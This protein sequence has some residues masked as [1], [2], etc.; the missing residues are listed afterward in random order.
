[1]AEYKYEYPEVD[2]KEI[3]FSP[4][5]EIHKKLRNA[6]DDKIRAGRQAGRDGRARATELDRTLNSFVPISDRENFLKMK[7]IDRP[8]EPLNIVIPVSKS[9]LDTWIT[10]MA[11]AFLGNPAGL[12]QLQGRGGP[13]GIV[14]AALHERFLNTQSIWFDHDLRHV[15]CWRDAFAYGLGCIAPTWGKHKRREPVIE[16]VSETLWYMIRN[17]VPGVK[18]GDVIRYLEERVVHEGNELVNVD[19]YSLI[20]D[21]NV[22]VSNYRRFEYAG[23]IE[24]TNVLDLLGKEPDPEEHLFNVK[25]LRDH[26]KSGYGRSRHWEARGQRDDDSSNLWGVSV[27]ENVTTDVIHLYWRLIPKDWGL[28]DSEEPEVHCFLLG[29]DEVIIGW[30][31]IDYDHGMLPMLFIAPNSTGYDTFPVSGLANT[32]GGQAF[33]DWKTRSMVA[34][35]AKVLNDMILIDTSMF[36]EDD[37]M[38]PEPGKLI[39]AKRSLYGMGGMDQFVKQLTTHDSS[40]G[41]MND[42]AAM[43]QIIFQGLGTVDMVQGDLSRAPD[44]PTAQGLM[45]ARNSALSRL[46]KDAQVMIS[47]MWYKLIHIMASN[48]VQYMSQDVMLSIVGSRFEQDIRTEL[49]LPEGFSD[50]KLTPWNL[51][52]NFDVMPINKMQADGDL[53]TMQ[54]LIER[55]MGIP[56]IA[57]S[58]LAPFDLPGMLT[59]YVRRAGF[60]NVHEFVRKGNALPQINAQTMPDEQV[61]SQQGA[62]NL[63]PTG[64]AF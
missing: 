44:R 27:G 61:L 16:D 51:D 36:E 25:Y 52:L 1:M 18:P 6:L 15:I 48:T 58:A 12:Y 26:V 28:G 43:M 37:V 54:G 41:N 49:G 42:V 30:Q 20:L 14:R 29:A 3:D 7:N 5:G 33:C 2:G 9:A 59:A 4:G 32:Y 39:R 23:W 34:N 38:N 17:V 63:V 45:A 55:I 22:P 24:R 19:Y 57:M 35:Q 21:P 46:Q 10:Y 53:A 31:R 62:G 50:V 8:A 47:Q 40:G 64:Q 11:G 56:E 60:A 13:Q